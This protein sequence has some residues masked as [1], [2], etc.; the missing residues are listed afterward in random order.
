MLPQLLTHVTTYVAFLSPQDT[1]MFMRGHVRPEVRDVAEPNEPRIVAAK[2]ERD[3][4]QHIAVGSGL[5]SLVVGH[6]VAA[7]NKQTGRKGKSDC[8]SHPATILRRAHSAW[9]GEA[10]IARKH[11]AA[12]ER[13]VGNAF[14][15]VDATFGGAK[16]VEN[17]FRNVRVL[18][19]SGRLSL[20]SSSEVA[21]WR[22][23][24][25]GGTAGGLGEFFGG[26]ALSALGFYLFMSRVNVT[27]SLSSLWGGHGGYLLLSL[28][29]GVALLFFS[30]KS[31][32]GWLLTVGS[33]GV[34]FVSVIANLTFYFQSTNLFRTVA[35]LA[36]FFFGLILMARGV[37]DAGR[38]S[39]WGIGK[40]TR[41]RQYPSRSPA[42]N[43]PLAIFSRGDVA[44]TQLCGMRVG[45]SS[46]SDR[47]VSRGSSHG[48]K[49]AGRLHLLIT[50]SAR[51]HRSRSWYSLARAPRTS[52]CAPLRSPEVPRASPPPRARYLR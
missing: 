6:D 22:C 5:M 41:A 17:G 27:T 33:I 43:I 2:I 10:C 8:V 30:A 21:P 42:P 31:I 35:M 23:E 20:V 52:R 19:R 1:P 32:L 9:I 48:E 15:N 49:G 28:S 29:F 25:Q 37:R 11:D 36:L 24:A 45:R 16:L 26:A 18:L 40:D 51:L 38:W 3:A 47:S 39:R 7:V 12:P 34:V 4:L 44:G 50:A 14:L 46:A 13:R